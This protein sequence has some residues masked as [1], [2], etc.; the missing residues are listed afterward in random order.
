M[1]WSGDRF[2]YPPGLIRLVL[3]SLDDLREIVYAHDDPATETAALLWDVESALS[4]ARLTR[5]QRQILHLHRQG[6]DTYHISIIQGISEWSARGHLMAVENI[7]KN[8]LNETH[9][10]GA[11]QVH[12]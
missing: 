7:L 11:S 5:R 10:N 9:R 2:D 4:H 12:E 8:F 3:S 1:P 6:Y